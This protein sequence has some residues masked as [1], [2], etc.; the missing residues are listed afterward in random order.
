MSITR[1]TALLSAAAL[2]LGLSRSWALTEF[3]DGD[4][5]VQTVSDGKLVLPA[6]LLVA[7][8]AMLAEIRPILA[9]A[10]I[11]DSYD[12]PLNVTL[13]RRGDQLVLFDAGSGSGFMQDAGLL[14]DSLAAIGIAPEDITH[15]LFTHAHPD[16]IWGVLDDF[17]EPLFV[18]A[19][20]LINRTE[21]DFWMDP[22]TMDSI[23]P[24]RQSFVS[25]ARRRIETLGDRL[26]SF[27]DG[28]EVLPGVTARLTPGHTPGHTSFDIDGRFMVI[29]DAVT[30]AHLALL[31][32]ELL[33]GSDQDPEMAAT[34]RAA[35]LDQ[36]AGSGTIISGY[37]LPNGGMGRIERDGSH[38]KFSEN[39]H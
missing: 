4:L 38:F 11:G 35:L 3:R 36:L 34:T 37:H 8:P 16:H 7:D 19:A 18:N 39:L 26:Q 1:R 6:D 21:R 23:D 14:V 20:H 10:G 13:M 24:S 32:P 30:N 22:A 2:G 17:D 5:T 9:D 33:S 28:D 15:L 12:S 31:R 29:G 27:D 25:G